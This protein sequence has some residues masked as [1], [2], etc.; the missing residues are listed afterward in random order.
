MKRLL[1]IAAVLV[2]LV[3]YAMRPVV[4]PIVLAIFFA[5]M[6]RPA[7]TWLKRFVPSAVSLTAGLLQNH[8]TLPD[9]QGNPGRR[10]FQTRQNHRPP[11][12]TPAHE[13]F[14]R[15]PLRVGGRVIQSGLA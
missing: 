9:H 1:V 15:R 10:E 8:R 4:L 2:G 11:P 5:L 14:L 7:H 3:F 6:V 12:R 13:K